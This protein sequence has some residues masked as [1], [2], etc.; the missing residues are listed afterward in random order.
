MAKAWEVS[1]SGV[2]ETLQ[3][4]TSDAYGGAQIGAP[5]ALASGLRVPAL[6]SPNRYLFQ[7]ATIDVDAC[8]AV[9][10]IGWRQFVSIGINLASGA[11]P[12][13]PIEMQVTSPYWKFLDGN[14]SF[15]LVAEPHGGGTSGMPTAANFSPGRS[16]GSALLYDP[17]QT[18]FS[19]GAVDSNGNP[20]YYQIGMTAY[21]P[22]AGISSRWEDVV[23]LSN[24]H[25]IRAPWLG[26]PVWHSLDVEVE[27]PRRLAL[28]ASVLQTNPS[29]RPAVTYPTGTPD[30]VTTPEEYFV[31]KYTQIFDNGND[32]PIIW[33]V[34]G[35]LIVEDM[36][37]WDPKDGKGN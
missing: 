2:D 14:W 30:N 15:H 27:G 33:R 31:S 24:V 32:G 9:H 5:P 7:L 18:T 26:S 29:T 35:S 13:L 17:A 1:A 34:G 20:F 28:Y 6:A 11:A 23:G 16:K 12:S 4:L 21:A 25:D 22:P 10:L 8:E 3:G 37:G 19:A 36:K